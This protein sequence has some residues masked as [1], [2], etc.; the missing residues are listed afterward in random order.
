[1]GVEMSHRLPM[2]PT[3]LETWQLKGLMAGEPM[4][5]MQVHE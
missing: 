4:M 2:L 5:H 3:H 1:M